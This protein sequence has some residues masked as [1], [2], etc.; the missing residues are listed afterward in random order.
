MKLALMQPYFFPYLAY[1]DIINSVD[2][3]IV[4][5]TAQYIH[6]G[7]I[8]RNRIL[9]ATR[10]WQYIIVPIK[11]HSHKTLIKDIMI[12]NEQNWKRKIIGKQKHYKKNAPYFDETLAFV[13]DCL[14]TEENFI[15]RLNVSILDKV[16]K[17]LGICFYYSFLSEMNMELRPVERPGDW[18]LRLSEKMAAEEYVNAPG[19]AHLFDEYNFRQSNV[20]LT[21]RKLPT[22]EY[23]CSAYDFIP[24]LS[25]IDL[26]MWNKP[27]AIKQYLDK[28]Q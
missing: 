1:F 22:F 27:E 13:E 19:G 26:F 6:S 18:G 12:D 28:N 15:S 11:K 9:H 10:G 21:F 25:I 5:D 23:S 17:R 16:C 2:K 14:A 3:W 4:F 20:K 8:H 24:N 7:W